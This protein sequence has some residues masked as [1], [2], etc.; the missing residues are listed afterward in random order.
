MSALLGCWR[1]PLGNVC[2][3]LGSDTLGVLEAGE[4][5]LVLDFILSLLE[6][7]LRY[8]YHWAH[9]LKDVYE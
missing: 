3:P 7:L 4:R 1:E 2:V 5:A 8:E 6:S 9:L